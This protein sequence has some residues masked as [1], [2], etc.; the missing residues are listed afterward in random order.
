MAKVKTNR[1]SSRLAAVQA[2]YELSFDDRAIDGI[3]RDF[4]AGT[5]GGEVIDEHPETGSEEFVP[6]IPA[7]PGLFS[8]IMSS[9]AENAERINGIIDASFSEEWS[10]DRVEMILKAILQ[11]GVAELLA[12][13]DTPIAIIISEYVDLAK[14]FYNGPEVRVT[15]GILDKL[16]KT[17]REE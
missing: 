7:E 13:P 2:L 5:V 9:Y 15:N 4:L 1:S 16:A 3:V 6:V 14:C 10:K 17:L 12:Y 11:A 8:G